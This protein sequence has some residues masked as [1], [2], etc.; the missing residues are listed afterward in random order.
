MFN[1]S[2]KKI[3][4]CLQNSHVP[5]V[6]KDRKLNGQSLMARCST[7][8]GLPESICRRFIN[9]LSILQQAFRGAVGLADGSPHLGELGA[10]STPCFLKVNGSPLHPPGTIVSQHGR[11]SASRES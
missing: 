6:I 10:V 2:T 8:P 11:N 9:R 1:L 7:Q 5:F 3:Q 4:H